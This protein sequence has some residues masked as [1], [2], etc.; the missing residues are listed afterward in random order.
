MR[1]RGL[2]RWLDAELTDQVPPADFD[3]KTADLRY[4]HWQRHSARQR[5]RAIPIGG[6]L[7][8]LR[9]LRLPA[10]ILPLLQ[11][12]EIFGTGGRTALGL[13]AFTL[14]VYP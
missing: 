5:D 13:G 1:T 7:G 11:I 6:F 4:V 2:A 12:A 9:I 3:I 14:A 8:K 10:P